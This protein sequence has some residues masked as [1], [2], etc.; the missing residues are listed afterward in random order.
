MPDNPAAAAAIETHWRQT[1]GG[2]TSG[3]RVLDVATGNG[4]LLSWASQVASERGLALEL[5]GIDAADIDPLRFVV[6]GQTAL[7]EVTFHGGV[8]AESLPFD[9]AVFD[10]VVSQFGLEYSDLDASL[11]EAARVLAPGGSLHWLAHD[12]YSDVVAQSALQA[13]QMDFLLARDAA[14]DAMA[15]FARALQQGRRLGKARDRLQQV[16]ADAEAYSREHPPATLVR[17]I[18]SSFSHMAVENQR[19]HP[20]DI[21]ALV[22][23]NRETMRLYRRRLRDLLAAQLT[24]EREALVR[25]SLSAAS[26]RNVSMVPL[27]ASD[28]GDHLGSVIVATRAGPV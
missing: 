23:E 4:V 3:C 13:A 7:R 2:L 21:A 18:C 26:W 9:D 20:D 8:G 27:L 6:S 5:T 24:P 1:F 25:E 28:S 14:F 10:C 15:F 16:L 17:Q 11:A 12:A 22:E 19:Y